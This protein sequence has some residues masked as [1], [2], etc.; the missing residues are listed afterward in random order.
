MDGAP[1]RQPPTHVEYQGWPELAGSL[2]ETL[3]AHQPEPGLRM[4]SHKSQTES[5]AANASARRLIPAF[6]VVIPCAVLLVAIFFWIAGMTYLD[7]PA[8][9]KVPEASRGLR[10][11]AGGK[12]SLV[13]GGVDSLDVDVNGASPVQPDAVVKP[14]RP[15]IRPL[16]RAVRAD[17]EWSRFPVTTFD[18]LERVVA[19]RALVASQLF[20]NTHLNPDDMFIAPQDRR[21]LVDLIEFHSAKIS[22]AQ[23]G[24]A[25]VMVKEMEAALSRADKRLLA[26]EAVPAKDIAAVEHRAGELARADAIAGARTR[27]GQPVGGAGV[28]VGS[29]ALGRAVAEYFRQRGEVVIEYEGGHY[30]VPADTFFESRSLDRQAASLYAALGEGILAWAMSVGALSVARAD[31]QTERLRRILSTRR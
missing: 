23:E 27:P 2:H 30:Q 12:V 26:I 4:L 11:A 29:D 31:S 20:R 5:L 7:G 3:K 18:P 21:L 24:V 28:V 10:S 22:L 17:S 1:T 13:D 9:S 15:L 6:V 19:P 14:A 25:A 8:V 16:E